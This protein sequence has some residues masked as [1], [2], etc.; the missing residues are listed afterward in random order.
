M[1][2]VIFRVILNLLMIMPHTHTLHVARTNNDVCMEFGR[3]FLA[4]GRCCFERKL[5]LGEG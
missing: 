2:D 3:C 5:Q 4:D 1:L